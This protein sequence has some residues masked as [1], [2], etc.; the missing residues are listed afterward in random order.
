MLSRMNKN[1]HL[2]PVRTSSYRDRGYGSTSGGGG[3]GVRGPSSGFE[4]R[5]WRSLLASPIP[6]G[7]RGGEGVLAPRSIWP[8]SRGTNYGGPPILPRSDRPRV[9]IPLRPPARSSPEAPPPSLRPRAAPPTDR[10]I[11]SRRVGP[12]ACARLIVA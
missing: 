8:R 7:G 5:R 3:G 9:D 4:R 11:R 2:S 1:G 12:R 6:S 10:A